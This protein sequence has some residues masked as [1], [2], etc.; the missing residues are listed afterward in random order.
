VIRHHPARQP[1]TVVGVAGEQDVSVLLTMEREA[2]QVLA[3]LDGAQGG[4]QAAPVSGDRLTLVVS[5][6][7]P[8]EARVLTP[9]RPLRRRH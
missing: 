1:G 2:P 4:G 7:N 8:C 9:R 6:E 3:L 5:R